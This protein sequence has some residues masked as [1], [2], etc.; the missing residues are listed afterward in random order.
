MY[1]QFLL[2]YKKSISYVYYIVIDKLFVYIVYK[3]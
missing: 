2:Y 3:L 1:I